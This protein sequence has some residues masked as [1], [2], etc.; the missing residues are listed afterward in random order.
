MK[1]CPVVVHA[2]RDHRDVEFGDEC[3]EV[4]GFFFA[5]DNVLGGDDLT[6]DE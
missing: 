1:R 5:P 3:L 4:E 6:L 2:A